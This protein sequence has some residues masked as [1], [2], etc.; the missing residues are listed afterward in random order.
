MDRCHQATLIPFEHTSFD[1]MMWWCDWRY[2]AALNIFPSRTCLCPIVSEN[3]LY[4][5]VIW[6]WH[7][8]STDTWHVGDKKYDHRFQRVRT[9]HWHSTDFCNSL[10]FNSA[11]QLPSDCF[12]NA[13][14]AFWK[15]FEDVRLDVAEKS[16][17]VRNTA[18]QR[19]FVFHI[20]AAT[21]CTC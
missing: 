18:R 16:D 19:F 11:L 4:F 21:C 6:Q 17:G 10:F 8:L 12:Q 20:R 1:V 5:N 3:V 2:L 15:H 13:G 9:W 7:R 14:D